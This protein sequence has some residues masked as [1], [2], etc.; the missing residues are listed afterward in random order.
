MKRPLSECSLV[1]STDLGV[2]SYQYQ[3]SLT[4]GDLGAAR[5]QEILHLCSKQPS[6]M[7]F[8]GVTSLITGVC[9]EMS[10]R[11]ML[12]FTVQKKPN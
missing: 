3:D 7:L 12:E 6:N 1:L 11:T 5:H 10:Q 2:A 8:W 9:D 4:K